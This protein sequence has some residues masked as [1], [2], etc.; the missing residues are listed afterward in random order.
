MALQLKGEGE[1][2]KRL[3]GVSNKVQVPRGCWKNP[4]ICSTL[5][6][7][8]NQKGHFLDSYYLPWVFSPIM[9]TTNEERYS[10][11]ESFSVFGISFRCSHCLIQMS[12]ILKKKRKGKKKS[13]VSSFI[14]LWIT[15]LAWNSLLKSIM[16]MRMRSIL[17][18]SKY[19][20]YSW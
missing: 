10:C 1:G 6:S 5:G 17:T 20:Y 4:R 9:V 8:E 7:S 19:S 15:N 18:N 3:L 16:W 11:F 13:L 14:I 12:N 2:R